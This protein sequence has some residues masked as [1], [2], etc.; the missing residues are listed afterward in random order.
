M[1]SMNFF[2]CELVQE[3][4]SF[5]PKLTD[6]EAFQPTGIYEGPALL[7][8]GS[9]AG[10]T[11]CGM[12]DTVRQAGHTA[13]G[14]I[15]MRAG[16]DGPVNHKL[17][18][19]FIQ[20]TVGALDK[21]PEVMLVSLHGATVS[22]T[23]EDVCGDILEAIR[24]KVGQ[25]C[26]IAVTCD[27]HAN[28]TNKFINNCDLLCGYQSYPHLDQ[29]ETGCR[30]A[31][32]AIDMVAGKNYKTVCVRLPMM[33]PAHGYTTTSGA[34]HTLMQ[35]GHTFVK[36]GRLADF[37]VFQVQPWLDV[38]EIA[39]AVVVISEDRADA[40]N[41]AAEM[42]RDE[43]ELRREL[44]GTPLYSVEEVIEKA[45][46][47]T[48]DAPVVLV[49]SADSP[50][51]GATGD[52]ATVIEKLLPYKDELSIAVAV[53]D[54]P[55]VKK[56]FELG[57]G[58]NGDFTLGA[59]LA[60]KLSKPVSVKNCTVKSLHC[61]DFILEGPAERKQ[62]RSVGKSAVLVTGNMQ[63]LVSVAGHNNGDKQFYRGFG[64]EPTLCNLVC[65]KACTSFRAG[66]E[67]ISAE[68]CNAATPGAAGP[69]LTGLPFERLPHPFFPFEEISREQITEPITFRGKE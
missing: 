48:C 10:A 16:S 2:V 46:K 19:D 54:P 40:C 68:I 17:A 9:R 61:G 41:I 14:G 39:S 29:Y 1:I 55:A 32:L 56:A 69:L 38:N 63:I 23:S 28:I 42:A 15:R 36:E 49:D 67:S 7:A 53:I 11:V 59:T 52:C 35:K 34:L 65:V 22:D 66:Y 50:N 4:N 6:I 45:R 33:A 43:F 30:A 13:I 12:L 51:A 8:A 31:K 25:E 27:L 62:Y 20:R 57:V 3:S 44:L 24:N 21:I 5:N 60:P 37:S 58:G 47:N 18:K 26:I 64:I